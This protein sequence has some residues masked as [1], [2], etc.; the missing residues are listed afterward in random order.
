MTVPQPAYHQLVKG[1]I[2]SRTNLL[3]FIR[4]FFRECQIDPGLYVEFGVL[5]GDSI[6]QAN[7][8]LRGIVTGYLGFDTFS[9]MP[10]LSE[11]DAR[12]KALHPRFDEGNYKSLGQE[13]VQAVLQGAGVKPEQ[14]SLYAKD[15]REIQPAEFEGLLKKHP[16]KPRIVHV[17]LDLHS[18]TLSAL[19]LVVPHVPS[20]SWF[21]FD[22]YWCYQGAPNC[23][24][25]RALHDFVQANPHAHFDPYTNYN[26]W[27]RAFI[28]HNLSEA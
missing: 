20:G 11:L 10:Q 4:E 24:V 21:L 18:S 3:L 7:S 22:D 8:I 16:G 14:V 25:R 6:K 28:Y 15:V 1:D 13:T 19:N 5:N 23:G 9:G 26:G 27:G 12:C 2:L 17:D